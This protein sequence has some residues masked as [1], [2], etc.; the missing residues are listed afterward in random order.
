MLSC[1]E[2]DATEDHERALQDTCRYVN[3]TELRIINKG[4]NDSEHLFWRLP[5][6]LK[7]SVRSELWNYQ[8]HSAGFAVRFRTNS[9]SLGVRYKLLQ[10]FS[11]PNMAYTGIKGVD[12]YALGSDSAWHHAIAYKP[13]PDSD[14]LCEGTLLNNVDTTSMTEYMLYFPLYDGV[15][16]LEIRVKPHAR[17]EKGD[18]SFIP[19]A[20]RIVAYGTSIMQGGCASRPGMAATNILS[21]ELNCEVVN[22][23]FSSQG[24]MDYCVARAMSQ[25]DNVV[26]YI[27]DPVPNCTPEMC[28]TLTYGFISILR[29]AKPT[30]PVIMVEGGLYPHSRLNK[31]LKETIVAKNDAFRRNFLKLQ[32]DNPQNLYYIESSAFDAIEEEGTVDGIHLSNLG[33]RH[34]ADMLKP[35]LTKL[36]SE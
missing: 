33:F 10:D 24:K 20:K 12:L 3:A 26:A 31:L 32:E 25:M 28:D 35:L 14:R 19:C 8:Q 21:R 4:F 17:V 13:M 16:N 11:I 29:N 34:Y 2:R 15:E 7:D 22:L 9:E 36:L 6:Y 30:V 5:A 27:I 18:S 23:G 1:S